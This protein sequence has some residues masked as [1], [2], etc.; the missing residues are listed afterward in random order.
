MT[1]KNFKIKLERSVTIVNILKED[2]DFWGEPKGYKPLPNDDKYAFIA[3]SGVNDDNEIDY[4]FIGQQPNAEEIVKAVKDD[5]LFMAEAHF[6][7]YAKGKK[8]YEFDGTLFD[9][10]LVAANE[11]AK[12]DV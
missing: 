1:M 12:Y 9:A 3:I 5:K 2:T 8:L 6:S 4:L 7:V 10:L 11:G